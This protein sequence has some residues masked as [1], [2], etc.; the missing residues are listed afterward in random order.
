MRDIV[1]GIYGAWRLARLDRGGLVYFDRSAEGFWKSFFA[2]ALVAP[3]YLILVTI[4]LA[5]RETSAGALR[6]LI[7]HASAYTLGWTVYPIFTRAIC[8][9]IGRDNAY[10]SFIVAFNWAQVIQMIVYLPIIVLSA[11]GLIPEGLSALL[12]VFVYSIILAYQWFVT[13]TTLD[14]SSFAAIGFIALD[15]VI[16]IVITG[17][18][19]GMIR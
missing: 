2:A 11:L 17:M 14:I 16:S 6:L 3:A 18:A 8:Q 1:Y 5:E 19:D 4:D 7:V 12:H 15:L 9:A 13:R 10:I